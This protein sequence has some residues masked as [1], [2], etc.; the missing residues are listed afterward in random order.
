MGSISF[1]LDYTYNLRSMLTL[2]KLTLPSKGKELLYRMRIKAKNI[3]TKP[4]CGTA[5]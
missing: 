5:E 2:I 1:F 3:F 4:V